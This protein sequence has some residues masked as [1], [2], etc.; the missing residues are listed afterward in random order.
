MARTPYPIQTGNQSILKLQQ[1]TAQE[2]L[3]R[4]AWRN[5]LLLFPHHHPAL[6]Q[7]SSCPNTLLQ[8]S[9]SSSSRDIKTV[10]VFK[11]DARQLPRIVRSFK[12]FKTLN[13]SPWRW[14]STAFLPGTKVHH[15]LL[16]LQHSFLAVVSL[17]SGGLAGTS[18]SRLFSLTLQF[19]DISIT[20]PSATLFVIA[21][22]Q[23]SYTFADKMESNAR[24][25]LIEVSF[26]SAE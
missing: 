15:L 17:R 1:W 4:E 2:P 12:F 5:F 21:S 22:P 3:K 18:S 8:S 11:L 13:P 26:T 9:N 7:R 25:S 16:L 10:E 14:L 24:G 19:N 23:S 6:P 20:G